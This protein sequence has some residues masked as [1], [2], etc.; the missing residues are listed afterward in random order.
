[1]GQ[2]TRYSFFIFVQFR[3]GL[4]WPL[5]VSHFSELWT[6]H[7][8]PPVDEGRLWKI[9]GL[10]ETA[11]HTLRLDSLDAGKCQ[12]QG[13]RRYLLAD[14]HP[15]LFCCSLL[16]SFRPY[17]LGARSKHTKL[18]PTLTTLKFTCMKVPPHK[19]RVATNHYTL[20]PNTEG[21]TL[22]EN[23]TCPSLHS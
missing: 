17:K 13:W 14:K 23:V 2:C 22:N 20:D 10:R 18:F 5:R 8:Q 9:L 3:F 4:S 19:A 6:K 16:F 21:R 7:D 12:A 11:V 1:M 15:C